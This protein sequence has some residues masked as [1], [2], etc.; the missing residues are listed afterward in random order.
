MRNQGNV[1]VLYYGYGRV[2]EDEKQQLGLRIR[3]HRIQAGLTMDTVAANAGCSIQSLR[4]W[5]RGR[6][7]PLPWRLGPLARAIGVPVS[8]LLD[9]EAHVADITLSRETLEAIRREGRETSK[10]AADRLASMLEPV[11]WQLATQPAVDVSPGARAVKKRRTRRQ[12]LAGVR[13]AD[14]MA[15][16]ARRRRELEIG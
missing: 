14:R 3:R 5:E 2:Y 16:A 9:D 6:H 1:Y 10:N 15:A 13:E 7:A 12:V 4:G 11:I 8:A